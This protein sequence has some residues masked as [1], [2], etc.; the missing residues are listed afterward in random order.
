MTAGG[1]ITIRAEGAGQ[2]S[3]LTVSGSQIRADG[4]AKL[5]AEGD[6][7]LLA[8]QNTAEQHSSQSSQSGSVGV[9]PRLQRQGYG[10]TFNASAS[11]SRGQADGSDVAWTNTRSAGQASASN[12]VE[13]PPS[14]A[15]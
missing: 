1:K 6:I 11:R 13:T 7:E 8:G 12:P 2:D 9:G 4:T 14:K 3:D 10:V 15:P 5:K